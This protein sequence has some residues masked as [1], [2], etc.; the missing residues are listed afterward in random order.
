MARRALSPSPWAWVQDH[1]LLALGGI[2]LILLAGWWAWTALSGTVGPSPGTAR[3]VFVDEDSTP[4]PGIEVLLSFKGETQRHSTNADGIVELSNMGFPLEVQVEVSEPAFE[5]YSTIWKASK[6]GLMRTFVLKPRPVAFS[7]PVLTFVDDL[8]EKLEGVP[9]TIQLHCSGLS[10]AL[11]DVHAQ[12]GEAVLPKPGLCGILSVNVYAPGFEELQGFQVTQASHVIFLSRIKTKTGSVRVDVRSADGVQ[13]EGIHV[14]LFSAENGLR[15]EGISNAQGFIVF[16]EISVGAY[17]ASAYDSL[18]VLGNALSA[19]FNV[20]AFQ[21]SSV[22]LVMS[23]QPVGSVRVRAL[24]KESFQEIPGV[25]VKL[26]DPA[27]NQEMTDKTTNEN[28]EAVFAL[29]KQGPFTVYGIHDEYVYAEADTGIVSGEKT[30]ELLM[31]KY[32]EENLGRAI[33]QVKDTQGIGMENAVVSVLS[34][35][36]TVLF[37]YP[38]KPTNAVGEASFKSLKP[39]Q[40]KLRAVKA[41]YNGI[42]DVMQVNAQQET[43]FP[44][45]LKAGTGILRVKVADSKGLPVKDAEVTFFTLAGSTCPAAGCG[46]KT[47]AKGTAEKSF[48]LDEKVFFRVHAQGYSDWISPFA[49]LAD[50]KSVEIQASMK[51]VQGFEP[52][53]VFVGWKELNGSIALALWPGQ[54]YWAEFEARFPSQSQFQGPG[55]HVRVENPLALKVASVEEVNAPLAGILKGSTFSPPAG[56]SIDELNLAGDGA[57]WSE[58]RWD[59]ASNEIHAVRVLVRVAEGA[60]LNAKLE[61]RYRTWGVLSDGKWHRFPSDPELGL[62]ENV[63]GK[64]ALYAQAI[65]SI[66]FI[67]QNESCVNALCVSGP[68]VKDAS[69]NTLNFQPFELNVYEPH[70]FSWVV[71]NKTGKSLDAVGL[72]AGFS[73][74]LSTAF[75][76]TGYA[77]TLPGGTVV[78]EENISTQ[79]IPAVEGGMLSIG[80]MLPNESALLEVK[81]EALDTETEKLELN[82]LEEGDTKISGSWTLIGVESAALDLSV[83]PGIVQAFTPVKVVA[84]VA[85]AQGSPVSNAQVSVY[86]VSG[87]GDFVFF[88]LASTQEDGEVSIELDEAGPNTYWAFQAIS[89]G[90]TSLLVKVPVQGSTV[91][92]DPKTLSFQV[93]AVPGFS[94]ERPLY[95]K[96]NSQD[97]LVLVQA[98]IVGEGLNALDVEKMQAFLQQYIS[99]FSLGPK[100]VKTMNIQAVASSQADPL[101]EPL[102]ALALFEFQS[103]QSPGAVHVLVPLEFNL[104]SFGGCETQPLVI[105]GEADASHPW[106]AQV[107]AQTVQAKVLLSNQCNV[108]GSGVTLEDLRGKVTW[109][110]A[111]KGYVDVEIE[112]PTGKKVKSNLT[113]QGVSLL[114]E[115]EYFNP[116][117]TTET[118]YKMRIT[119]APFEWESFDPAQFEV[120]FEARTPDD[121]VVWDAF[122]ASITTNILAKCVRMNPLPVP[123]IV[124]DW[125]KTNEKWVSKSFSIDTT[126]CPEPVTI[127]ICKEPGNSN[128][129]GGT[130]DE[131]HVSPQ[132]VQNLKGVQKIEVGPIQGKTIPGTY[133][134]TLRVSSPSA[135]VPANLE[136][137]ATFKEP[138]HYFLALDKYSLQ[139]YSANARDSIRATNRRVL[140]DIAVTSDLCSWQKSAEA[141]DDEDLEGGWGD[142]AFN[143]T[144]VFFSAVDVF[145]GGTIGGFT[146]PTSV[147]LGGSFGPTA[148]SELIAGAAQAVGAVIGMSADAVLVF[149]GW[150]GLILAILAFLFSLF[151]GGGGGDVDPCAIMFTDTLPDYITLLSGGKNREKLPPDAIAVGLSGNAKSDF[152]AV[153]DVNESNVHDVAEGEKKKLRERA[154]VSFYNKTGLHS[155]MPAYATASLKFTEHIHGDPEHDGD[156]AVTCK[157]GTFGRYRIGPESDEGECSPAEDVTRVEKFHVRLQTKPLPDFQNPLEGFACVKNGVQGVT[158]PNVLPKIAFNWSWKEE[159]GIQWNSCDAKN[160]NAIYC[161]ATQ[162]NIMLMKRMQFFNAFLEAND[163]TFSCPEDKETV[164]FK[165]GGGQT[166][167]VLPNT[168]AMKGAGIGFSPG[169]TA[170]ITVNVKNKT[171]ETQKVLYAVSLKNQNPEANIPS[172]CI[173][174]TLVDGNGEFSFSCPF[175]G[176]EGPGTYVAQISL[177]SSPTLFSG[178]TAFTLSFSM[179]KAK[180]AFEGECDKSYSTAIVKGYPAIDY[181][182]DKENEDFGEYVTQAG[183]VW[184]PDIPHIKAL[185]NL[186]YFD[187]K[188]MK[189]GFSPDFH[190]DFKE[191]YTKKA[192]ADTP[193]WFYNQAG[194]PSFD[195]YYD[196]NGHILIKRR[197]NSNVILDEP[198]TYEVETKILFDKKKWDFFDEDKPNAVIVVSLSHKKLPSPNSLWYYFPL[199]GSVGLTNENLLNREGYGT[200]F[201]LKGDSFKIDEK[202]EVKLFSSPST[203]LSSTVTATWVRDFESLNQLPT[204]RGTLFELKGNPVNNQVYELSFS[205]TTATPLLMQVSRNEE[206]PFSAAYMSFKGEELEAPGAHYTYWEGVGKACFNFDGQL[207]KNAFHNTPDTPATVDDVKN[208]WEYSYA[209]RF[210]SVQQKGTAYVKSVV[211]TPP[212]EGHSIKANADEGISVKFLTPNSASFNSGAALNGISGLA[213]DN[214]SAQV[215]SVQALFDMVKKQSACV[216]DDGTAFEVFWNPEALQKGIGGTSMELEE[217]TFIQGQTC[218]GPL[219]TG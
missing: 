112:T 146:T 46:V 117:S 34:P 173:K 99:T 134:V 195:A 33:A 37:Q 130:T 176:L 184:T 95:F 215:T 139:L 105:A 163:N 172:P 108:Q 62:N 39:G 190:E 68:F 98:Q 164:D 212:Q 148:I 86:K 90:Q 203:D 19:A 157:T 97:S 153:W 137:R 106:H 10:L 154:G 16:N 28:G 61:L 73:N 76:V 77:L 192:F 69:G 74:I 5:P 141:G 114:D 217:A 206:K 136:M 2:A 165:K 40:Y 162:F 149:F 50:S 219:P 128:C 200:I 174:E 151:G 169:S 75:H 168:V 51:L 111:I 96:N 66:Y 175:S 107:N 138:R 22:E 110:G 170:T 20:S 59:S 93:N 83:E 65:Q 35:I 166:F 189:D 145:A 29:S 198:G 160:P 216:L 17:H 101:K 209:L 131:I 119:Y 147:V 6:P 82:V 208:N 4:L 84:R 132:T 72:N 185:N 135:Q 57:V 104:V 218:M 8:G 80:K 94:Q 214:E 191:Y 49:E 179:K 9:V 53:I 42:S 55:M 38:S 52:E 152:Y 67:G 115:L 140:E 3:L 85:N 161:D 121:T 127:E 205:P 171:S 180:N 158:G 58:A 88:A 188:L 124:V 24:D 126:A 36:G 133:G 204:K 129:R 78:E 186:L 177:S 18:N 120:R 210:P 207:L 48:K 143:A 14:Q 159:S 183:V 1:P 12:K 89:G 31:E 193:T 118:P 155:D 32:S 213:H 47:S 144:M 116:A 79:A 56:T 13:L 181:W 92:T 70:S 103:T 113:P 197:F 142:V 71:T 201:D 81:L 21:E 25:L 54:S 91:S 100:E 64:E 211:Y 196:E 43:V 122:S 60:P 11:E 15:A 44:I 194:G 178:V 167:T 45:T 156:A 187:A 26:V 87:T 109:K 202:N 182:I 30:I 123:G 199:D 102:H 125:N 41:P 27:L 23:L 63:Q 7:G 150:F